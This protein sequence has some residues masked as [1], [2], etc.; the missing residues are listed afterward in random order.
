MLPDGDGATDRA[1]R[2]GDVASRHMGEHGTCRWLAKTEEATEPVSATPRAP[3]TNRVVSLTAEPTPAWV[4][5]SEPMIDSVA[6]AMAKPIPAATIMLATMS[7]GYSG[8]D[9]SQ[10]R[11]PRSR[12]PS[13]P[14]LP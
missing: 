5:G 9:A 1:L 3:P 10:S 12:P 4:R 14:D 13:P 7:N 8:V 2:L 6:G 11:A